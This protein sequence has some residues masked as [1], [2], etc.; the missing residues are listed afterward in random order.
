MR[1]KERL[2]L[3]LKDAPTTMRDIKPL[4]EGYTSQIT[5]P[6]VTPY[7]PRAPQADSRPT[8]NLPALDPP[9]S[10]PRSP[11]ALL[12]WGA[13]GVAVGVVLTVLAY[14]VLG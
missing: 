8:R 14:S 11:L 2:L 12:L 6:D 1:E 13:L 10:S 4:M 5:N 7:V 9:P 3:A